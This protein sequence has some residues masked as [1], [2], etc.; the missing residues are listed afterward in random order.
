MSQEERVKIRKVSAELLETTRARALS[1]REQ[2]RLEMERRLDEA[3]RGADAD[4]SSAYRVQLEAGE[5]PATVRQAFNRVKARIGV[6][7]GVNL[8]KLDEDLVIAKREQ[9]RGRRRKAA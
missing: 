6:V 8:F 2:R 1:P 3:I 7:D 5:K 9:R 4:P